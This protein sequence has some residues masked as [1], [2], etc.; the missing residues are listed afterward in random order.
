MGANDEGG[1]S[2]RKEMESPMEID[3]EDA[4]G[5][6]QNS[7]V[8]VE[9]KEGFCRSVEREPKNDKWHGQERSS[10]KFLRRFRL[11]ERDKMEEVKAS[12]ENGVQSA[13]HDCA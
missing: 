4:D 3:R 9:A 10:G 8:K 12:L 6:H 13:Y 5:D 7:D 2:Y 11:P 1:R